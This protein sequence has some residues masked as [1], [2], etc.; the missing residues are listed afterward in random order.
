VD[1]DDA[2]DPVDDTGTMPVADVVGEDVVGEDMGGEPVDAADIARSAL[3]DARSVSRT[4]PGRR[5]RESRR[6][7]RRDNLTGRN[8][9]GYSA[10]G[11][12]PT[13]DPQLVGPLLSGYV[14]ALGWQQ[15]LAEA[16]VFADWPT[17]VG[18]DIAR[19]CE[20]QTLREGELRIAA[21]STAWA[22]QLRLLAAT[23]L[24]RLV[25]Q[26]GPDVVTKLIFT[27]PVGPSWK[28]GPRSVRGHR[29]P[30]DTYG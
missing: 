25:D 7:I 18:T 15:P 8:Q 5:D 28:H 2:R 16:R 9:G 27:G 11:P 13:S 3:A 24:K 30:R 20:P 21:E 1:N 4:I 29:G 23:M 17:L 26:L 22:T 14:E 10:P 19:H 12:D 6:R